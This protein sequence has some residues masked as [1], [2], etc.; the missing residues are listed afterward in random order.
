MEEIKMLVAAHKRCRLPHDDVYLPVQAGAALHAPIEGLIGDDT[1]VNISRKN[2]NYCELTVLYWAWKNLKAD[3]VGLSHYRRYFAVGRLP[4]GKWRR[5][6]PKSALQAAVRETGLVLPVKRH[7]WIESTYSQYAHA[8]HARDLD[9]TRE[10]LAEDWPEFLPAFDRVMKRSSGHRFNMFLMKRPLFDEYCEWLFAVL[11]RL[12]AGLDLSGYS[13]NDA[14]V[15]GFVGERLMDVWVETR[16]LAYVELPVVFTERQNWPRKVSA[17]LWRKLRGT[18][19][20]G[21]KSAGAIAQ[22]GENEGK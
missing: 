18:L 19:R 20:Q 8:H 10:I 12:E 4:L 7:Y 21:E 1:G 14:R 17:F 3:S 15:F 22:M 6:A 9:R 16:K 2:P 5:V 11:A 13:V